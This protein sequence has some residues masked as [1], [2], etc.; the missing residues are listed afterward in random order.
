MLTMG[1]YLI[2]LKNRKKLLIAY[3]VFSLKNLNKKRMP[4][5]VLASLFE[6]NNFIR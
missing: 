2:Q 3:G 5:D 1:V 4:Y 6:K